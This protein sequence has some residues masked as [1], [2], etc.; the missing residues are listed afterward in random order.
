MNKVLF[1]LLLVFII[2]GCENKQDTVLQSKEERAQVLVK[3]SIVSEEASPLPSAEI[4]KEVVSETVKAEARVLAK[5]DETF[6]SEDAKKII[7][8]SRWGGTIYDPDTGIME[9]YTGKGDFLGRMS[10]ES[11]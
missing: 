3:K 6:K 2:Y 5:A 4:K 9:Y 10:K 11:S 1:L 8:E 7:L